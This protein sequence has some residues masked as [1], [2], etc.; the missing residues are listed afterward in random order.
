MLFAQP[1]TRW[2]SVELVIGVCREVLVLPGSV[3]ARAAAARDQP[4][5]V[6]DQRL[7]VEHEAE[8][9]AELVGGEPGAVA[10]VVEA[11][12]EPTAVLGVSVVAGD[13][14]ADVAA[15]RHRGDLTGTC[16]KPDLRNVV[17]T[18]SA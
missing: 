16:N 7:L 6:A 2:I 13:L 18:A 15:A 3:D 9:A 12:E 10:L 8:G 11:R 5:P 14:G 17:W 4:R 1:F